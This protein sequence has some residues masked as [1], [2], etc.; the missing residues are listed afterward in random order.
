MVEAEE[1]DKGKVERE[2]VEEIWVRKEREECEECK[3]HKG[4][5]GY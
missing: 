5:K 2:D 1:I 4:Y 3:G